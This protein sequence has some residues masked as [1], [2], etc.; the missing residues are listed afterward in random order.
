MYLRMKFTR[1]DGYVYAAEDN[2][3]TT[4]ERVVNSL[5][6]FKDK[7]ESMILY[8]EHDNVVWTYGLIG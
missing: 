3:F 5:M 2:I 1:K 8:D 6:L 7:Y 4:M